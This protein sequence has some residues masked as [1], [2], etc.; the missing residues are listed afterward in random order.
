MMNKAS[1]NMSANEIR[2]YYKDKT[3]EKDSADA[4]AISSNQ[5]WW[6]EDDVYD[7]RKG[8][9]EH[10]KSCDISDSWRTIMNEYEHRIFNILKNEGIEIHKHGTI[11]ALSVFMNRNGYVDGSGWWIKK[12]DDFDEK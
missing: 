5:F 7:Y 12:T 8:T 2:E 6:L 3:T 1:L 11:S 4:F 10:Q 9:L